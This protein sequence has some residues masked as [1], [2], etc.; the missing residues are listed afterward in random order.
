VPEK[1]KQQ[2]ERDRASDRE[3]IARIRED[4][5]K[6]K[7]RLELLEKETHSNANLQCGDN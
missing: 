7:A 2:F 4:F 1:E 6:L 5:E 3:A